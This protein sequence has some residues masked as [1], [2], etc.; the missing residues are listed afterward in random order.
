VQRVTTSH[1]YPPTAVIAALNSK[2][3]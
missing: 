3:T 2:R 1:I